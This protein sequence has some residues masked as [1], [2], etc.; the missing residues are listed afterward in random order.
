MSNNKQKQL[1]DR[2]KQDVINFMSTES[3]RRFVHRIIQRAGLF[4]CSFSGQS[5]QT[6]FNEGGRNQGLMILSEIMTHASGSYQLM[7]KENTNG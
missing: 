6:I 7:L 2:E 1:L 4:R 3:G 5:N